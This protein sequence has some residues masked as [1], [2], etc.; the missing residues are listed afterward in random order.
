MN[1][2]TGELVALLS[3]FL[4][5]VASLLVRN[6]IVRNPRAVDNGMFATT[7]TN[8]AIFGVAAVVTAHLAHPMPLPVAG[9]LLFGLAGLLT[10]FVGRSTL[11]ASIRHLGASR[12]S[13][14]KITTPIFAIG[15]GALFLGELVSGLQLLGIAITVI[16]L[17]MLQRDALIAAPD[18]A[19]D[20]ERPRPVSA[21][22][23]A[24]L[25]LVSASSFGGGVAIRKVALATIPSPIL[26]A[27]VGSLVGC[28]SVLA[29]F[30]IRRE[31]GLVA[32]SMRPFPWAFVAAGCVTSAAQ[33]LNWLALSLAPVATVATIAVTE[34]LFTAALA[35]AFLRRSDGVTIATLIGV[36]IVT[37]G[38][39][40]ILL[41][42]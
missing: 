16:G 14:F 35:W 41:S 27:L 34:S 2:P 8:V 26:G 29:T 11:Y 37:T 6:G 3:A 22:A 20:C 42:A 39:I 15:A 12:A 40:V 30:S 13:G 21:A 4:F 28:I 18:D 23:G 17:A 31:I 19:A 32:M 10:T 25:G 5:A 38:V 24:T 33:L 1:A 36:A 7:L 9:I